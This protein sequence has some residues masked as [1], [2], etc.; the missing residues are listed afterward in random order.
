M[1]EKRKQ[2]VYIAGPMRG[3]PQYNFPLFYQVEEE[4]RALGCEVINPARRDVEE[5]GFD[6][7]THEPRSIAEYMAIDLPLVCGAD[8]VCLLE[9]WHGSHGARLEARTALAC[10]KRFM[11]YVADEAD[12][13]PILQW[14]RDC[15]AETLDHTDA[16]GE[17]RDLNKVTPPDEVRVTDSD[18]GAQKGSKLAR[19]DL[20]PAWAMWQVAEHYGKGAKKYADRNWEKGYAWSLSYAALH[21]HLNQFWGGEDFDAETGSHHMAAITFHALALLT[22]RDTNK[23][24]DDRPT[25]AERP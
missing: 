14:A 21:R 7:A 2:V 10:G 8:R 16:S 25:P 22:F 1:N 11:R 23:A 13:Y 5:D 4:L 20:I 18:T 6:P 15:V 17:W 3:I 9:G 12:G 19:F 24:K